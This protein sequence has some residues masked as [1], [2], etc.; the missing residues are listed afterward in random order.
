MGRVSSPQQALPRKRMALLRVGLV[1]V[2]DGQ[3]GLCPLR[4]R[5]SLRYSFSAQKSQ[6]WPP[7][8]SEV[9]SPSKWLRAEKGPCWVAKGL[10][11]ERGPSESNLASRCVT[12]FS[13]SAKW[14]YGG[15]HLLKLWGRPRPNTANYSYWRE[16][17]GKANPRVS[18]AG[19]TRASPVN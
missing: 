4:N 12:S 18:G 19:G 16:G 14:D 17:L 6:S 2:P 13:S 3:R 10:A 1:L 15:A 7:P 5:E 9:S 11:S 8:P